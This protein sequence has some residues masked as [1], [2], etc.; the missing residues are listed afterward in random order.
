MIKNIIN[1]QHGFTLFEVLIVMALFAM[2][3]TLSVVVGLEVY[4]GYSFRGEQYTLVAILQKARNQAI[5]NINQTPH[6]VHIGGNKYSIFEGNVYTS[7]IDFPI[8][9][10]FTPSGATDVVFTQLTGATVLTNIVLTENSSGKTLTININ[11][12]GQINY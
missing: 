8:S 9:N 10:G 6:G 12:E 7:G 5:N 3:A 2:C 1:Q 11:N 4:R